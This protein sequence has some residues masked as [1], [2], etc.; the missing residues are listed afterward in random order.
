MTL[1]A[2]DE[3]NLDGFQP[4]RNVGQVLAGFARP[5]FVAGGWAIDLFVGT[6]TR[7]HEDVEVLILREDQE[8]VQ[9]LLTGWELCKLDEAHGAGEWVPWRLGERI[10]HPAFQTQARRSGVD[11]LVLDVFLADAAEG[12]WQFRRDPR[13]TRPVA[14]IGDRAAIGGIP[15]I[16]PEIELLYKAKYHR[17]KDEH[18]FEQALPRLDARQRTWLREALLVNRPDDPWLTGLG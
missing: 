18:D 10:E 17:P 3:A 2:G 12:V 9:R 11:P 15:F 7:P 14:E 8:A 4:I 1:G 13:I 16:V 5:W 6:P